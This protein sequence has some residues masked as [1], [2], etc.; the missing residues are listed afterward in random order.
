MLSQSAASA[1]SSVGTSRWLYSAARQRLQTQAVL[2]HARHQRL[3]GQRSQLPQCVYAPG[4][5]AL[6]LGF[7]EFQ[8][9]ERQW[10]QQSPPHIPD[11]I[12]VTP[13]MP[14]AASTA[15]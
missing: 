1:G 2:A 15:A 14:R 13:C 9:G 8:H 11:A 12:A 6:C 3:C 5:E 7:V 10:R 4:R